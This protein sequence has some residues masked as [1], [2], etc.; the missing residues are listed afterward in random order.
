M[1]TLF[2]IFKFSWRLC[3][4]ALGLTFVGSELND[5]FVYHIPYDWFVDTA[6]IG[7][8]L[9]MMYPLFRYTRI[10]INKWRQEQKDESYVTLFA[11]KTVAYTNYILGTGRKVKDDYNEQE[12]LITQFRSDYNHFFHEQGE[13]IHENTPLQNTATQLYWNT[14]ALQKKRLDKKGITMSIDAERM[15]YNMGESPVTVNLSL[16]EAKG[17]SVKKRTEK[18][19]VKLLKDK[20]R[21]TQAVSGPEMM[22]CKNCGAPISLLE[23]NTCNYCGHVRH[24]S[25]F[26]WVIEEYDIIT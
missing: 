15:R 24:L 19:R 21:L 1:R 5:Y 12:R 17:K 6:V 13:G 20:N 18:F 4:A 14:L 11:S 16:L 8:G 9:L 3:L 22:N 2:E 23:G 25:K 7:V 26:D 10:K